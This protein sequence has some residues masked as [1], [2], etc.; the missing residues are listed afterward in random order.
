MYNFRS[1]DLE[2]ILQHVGNVTLFTYIDRYCPS[3]TRHL[4]DTLQKYAGGS[5]EELKL[6]YVPT[7][8]LRLPSHGLSSLPGFSGY[9]QRTA[10]LQA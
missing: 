2:T 9:D 3:Q 10:P 7:L 6:Q 4:D 8:S 1:E 5:L